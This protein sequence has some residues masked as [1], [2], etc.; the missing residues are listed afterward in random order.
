MQTKMMMYR[1]SLE[2]WYNGEFRECMRNVNLYHAV[3]QKMDGIR[4]EEIEVREL[5]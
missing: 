2:E 5:F 4:A 3:M 1:E